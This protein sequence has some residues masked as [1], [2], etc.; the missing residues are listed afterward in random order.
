MAQHTPLFL[1][2]QSYTRRTSAA[3]TGGQLVEVSGSGTVAPAAADSTKVIGVAGFDA[4]A[5]DIVTVHTAGVHPLAASGA[6]SA[7][8][9]VA[10]AASGKVAAGTT[11]VIGV[12]LDDAVDGI[13][14]V[15]L[16]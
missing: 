8:D 7:G 16:R 9:Q 13:V 11:A 2:G 4:A 10:A 14:T 1:P 5:G 12:A 15:D 6:I 3:V